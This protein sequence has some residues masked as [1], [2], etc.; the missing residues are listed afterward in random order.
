MLEFIEQICSCLLPSQMTMMN[1]NSLQLKDYKTTFFASRLEHPY[2]GRN[3]MGSAKFETVKKGG[4]VLGNKT[5]KPMS[6]Q[7]QSYK[8]H[9]LFQV[10]LVTAFPQT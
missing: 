3:K 7:K 10:A 6:I 5:L 9:W 1:Q 4:G 8:L 2:L